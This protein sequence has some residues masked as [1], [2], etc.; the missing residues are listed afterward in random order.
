MKNYL[1]FRC[2]VSGIFARSKGSKVTGE[3]ID[4]II[5]MRMVYTVYWKT[6]PILSERY[7]PMSFGEKKRWKGG[8]QKKK[9]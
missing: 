5:G 8:N 2:I 3:N 9:M 6:H 7:R 4:K 1:I